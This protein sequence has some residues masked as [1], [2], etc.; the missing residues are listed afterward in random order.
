MRA[1]CCPSSAL[2]PTVSPERRRDAIRGLAERGRAERPAESAE[3]LAATIGASDAE[4]QTGSPCS[5]WREVVELAAD[6]RPLV[7]ADRGPPLVQR[8]LLDLIESILQPRADIPLLMLALARPEL[9]D[10]DRLGR[11][12]ANH[13][14]SRSS[15]CDQASDRRRS[16]RGLLDGPCARDRRRRRGA[17]RGQPVLRRRD[18]ALARRSRGRSQRPGRG[19]RGRDRACPTP[20]T[21]PCSRAS[22]RS[23]RTPAACCSWAPCSVAR[24]SADGVPRSKAS[25]STTRRRSTSSSTANLLRT[26]GR[27]ELTF[28]HILIREVA[29]GTLP[30]A[31]RARLHGAAGRWLERARRGT[32]DELAELVAFH[33]RE[34][35]V[36]FL[37]ASASRRR[38]RP[39]IAGREPG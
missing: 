13:S 15:H 25:G 18:R 7:L 14:R 1:T 17:G 24:S 33:L 27:G 12:P 37:P 32:E 28:R 34:A 38:G 2:L 5:A 26:S 29:Y 4:V 23:S 35:A 19:G 11:R 8:L 30:R 31:E 20:S 6:R 21:P 9:L 16:S 10:D 22:T 39:A 36:L 3:L